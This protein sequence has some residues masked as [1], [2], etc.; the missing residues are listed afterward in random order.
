MGR[1]PCS[2]MAL[3]QPTLCRSGD[4]RFV[5]SNPAQIVIGPYAER[6][7]FTFPGRTRLEE[8]VEDVPRE[9][10]IALG[11]AARERYA[12]GVRNPASPS[13][14]ERLLLDVFAGM[15]TCAP[16]IDERIEHLRLHWKTEGFF[17]KWWDRTRLQTVLNVYTSQMLWQRSKPG[18]K[19]LGYNWNRLRLISTFGVDN[20]P[21]AKAWV[22]PVPAPS[23]EVL[24]PHV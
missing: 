23:L 9:A 11:R 5:G 16:D 19:Q 21:V 13:Q 17:H 12:R 4:E 8:Q 10:Q 15:E 14:F 18:M 20:C 6:M 22:N 1:E 24:S 2:C 3:L 7:R